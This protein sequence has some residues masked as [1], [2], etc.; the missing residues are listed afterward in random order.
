[1][2]S[3]QAGASK[4]GLL[5]LAGNAWQWTSSDFDESNKVLRGGSWTSGDPKVLRARNRYR[6]APSAGFTDI[7]FRC[8]QSLVRF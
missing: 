8:A 4:W 3:H 7:G 1:M 5:D 6:K 2:G